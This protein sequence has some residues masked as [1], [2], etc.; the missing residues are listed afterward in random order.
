MGKLVPLKKDNII[1][2][3]FLSM[4]KV[5]RFFSKYTPPVCR[6]TPTCSQYAYEAIKKYGVIKGG[7]L[8]IKRILKC[9]PY[10][11]GGY[12]PVP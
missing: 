1:Q 3:I 10:H 4:I 8:S 2:K 9:H 6:F 12:D 11:K 5:Y 7:F